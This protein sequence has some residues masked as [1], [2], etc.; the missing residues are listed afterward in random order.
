MDIPE[1]R[2]RLI[3]SDNIGSAQVYGYIIFEKITQRLKMTVEEKLNNKVLYIGV[4]Q[5]NPP[6]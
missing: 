2:V 5:I 6:I 1:T 4:S 3:A